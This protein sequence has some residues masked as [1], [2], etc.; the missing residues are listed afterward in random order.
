[1]ATY[2]RRI[3]LINRPFQL[4]FSAYVGGWVVALCFIYPL[5][6]A[7]L[8]DYF[9]RYITMDP[10]HGDI[11]MIYSTR[12]GVIGLLITTEVV[13]L[14]LT[15]L[16]SLFMSHRIAGPLYKLR[17]TLVE[18]SKGGFDRKLYFRKK[19]FFPEL[20]DDFNQMVRNVRERE[21]RENEILATAATRIESVMKSAS[22]EAKTE[23]ETALISIRK[24]QEQRTPPAQEPVAAESET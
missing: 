1:M 2:R 12:R 3:L 10:T 16:L 17:K 11:G 22:S 23:L 9:A 13:F 5:I 21:I 6:I 7:N 4:R 15:F 24:L 14:A 20:A 8:F 18:F 19:D